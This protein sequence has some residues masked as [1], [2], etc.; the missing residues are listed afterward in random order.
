MGFG[1][2]L[3]ISSLAMMNKARGVKKLIQVQQWGFGCKKI[4]VSSARRACS[5]KL[6]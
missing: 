3:L 2:I 4:S 6:N 5:F 1:F